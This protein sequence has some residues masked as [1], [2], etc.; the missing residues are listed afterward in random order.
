MN[1]QIFNVSDD[2]FLVIRT[3]KVHYNRGIPRS[4]TLVLQE[5]AVKT[6]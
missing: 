4:Y 2:F 3:E 5:T 1:T 6:V